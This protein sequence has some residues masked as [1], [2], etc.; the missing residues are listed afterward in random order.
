MKGYRFYAEFDS[1]EEKRKWNRA[2]LQDT[3]EYR[4]CVAVY[5]PTGREQLMLTN[6]VECASSVFYTPNSACNWGQC[7]PEYLQVKC[8]RVS[9]KLARKLHP[10]LFTYLEQ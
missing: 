1:H 10:E 5:L 6:N 9:E 7:N 8:I 4:N 3:N 2:K